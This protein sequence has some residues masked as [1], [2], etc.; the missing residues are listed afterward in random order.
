[1]ITEIT[2]TAGRSKGGRPKKAIKRSYVIK[3][4]CTILE[5]KVIERR[6]KEVGLPMSEYL[7]TKGLDGN[8]VR[9]Q[10]A[11]PKEFLEYKALLHHTASNLNQIARKVNS[12]GELNNLDKEVLLAL[13]QELK[14]HILNMQNWLQQ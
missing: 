7:R 10:K 2:K 6:A 13:E 1:M 9:Q 8:I 12:T 3:V 14:Q 4:K 11:L 5:R